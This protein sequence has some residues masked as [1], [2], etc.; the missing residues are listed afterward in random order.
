MNHILAFFDEDQTYSDRFKKFASSR[1]NCPFTIYSF[2]DY[3]DLKAFSQDH[4]IELL[5]GSELRK[6]IESGNYVLDKTKLPDSNDKSIAESESIYTIPAKS[7]IKLSEYPLNIDNGIPKNISG[8]GKHEIYKYQSGENILREII[9]VY[10]KTDKNSS[11]KNHDE[12]SNLFIIYSPIGRSGKTTFAKSL[13]KSLTKDCN[14]LYITLEEVSVYD[15][16]SCQNM[17]PGTLSEAIYFY[18]EGKLTKEKLDNLIFHANGIDH[19]LPVRSP[20]DI[21]TLNSTEL[22]DFIEQIR[23]ITDKDVVILDTDSI[24]S[25]VE[26]LLPKADHIFMPVTEESKSRKKMSL[27]ET[28]LKKTMAQDTLDKIIK[29]IIPDPSE[30]TLTD[31]VKPEHG[32]PIAGYAQAVIENYIYR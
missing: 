3:K 17:C 1:S 11:N 30:F 2:H 9:S 28:Y 10:G 14:P 22:N 13:T 26:C 16:S 18:K 31:N 8:S 24:L 4:P 32:D 21:T 25:R 20:E 6:P 19:I 23:L 27:L 7:I 12:L 5:V 29:L 15:T